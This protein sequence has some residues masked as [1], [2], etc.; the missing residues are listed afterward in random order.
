MDPTLPRRSGRRRGG[1]EG[2]VGAVAG[3]PP[4]RPPLRAVIE[5]RVLRQRYDDAATMAGPLGHLL[6]AMACP[7]VALGVIPF[8]AA[9][10][11]IRGVASFTVYDEDRVAIEW[12]RAEV[13]ITA[14]GDVEDC[15]RAFAELTKLAAVHGTRARALVAAAT[16][17]L[18]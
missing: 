9:R 1:G 10:E 13:D 18:E 4:P 2:P 6:T 15:V 3:A 12:P 16:D 5:E 17:A 8:G 7:Q 14:A 11:H